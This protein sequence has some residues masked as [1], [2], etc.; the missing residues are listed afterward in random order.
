[1]SIPQWF[2][3]QNEEN[4]KREHEEIR[5]TIK[6]VLQTHGIEFWQEDKYRQF[7]LLQWSRKFGITLELLLQTLISKFLKKVLKRR[8]R[9][10]A[11]GIR[12]STLS[13]DAAFRFLQDYFSRS[14]RDE[15]LLFEPVVYR[16]VREYQTK[17]A[18]QRRQR[19]QQQKK[20]KPY[21]SSPNWNSR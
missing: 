20:Q 8:I 10:N 7:I 16:S 3:K 17:M 11:L 12:I 2:A 9:N 18:K 6:R 5:A 13:G 4:W 19:S 1:M 15:T 21:R 14:S